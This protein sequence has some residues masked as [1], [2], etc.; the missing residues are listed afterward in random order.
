MEGN[1]DLAE[2]KLLILGA[3]QETTQLVEYANSMGIKTLVTSN[4]ST[5]AA[6][7]FAWKS[8]DVDGMDVPGVIALAKRENVDAS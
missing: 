7:K 8:Y 2:K 1:M 3:N 6:K 4:C 5:D